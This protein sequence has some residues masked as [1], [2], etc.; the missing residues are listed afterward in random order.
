MMQLSQE[1][2]GMSP[3]LSRSKA[4]LVATIIAVG[5]LTFSTSPAAASNHVTSVTGPSSAT[6][7]DANNAITFTAEYDCAGLTRNAVTT[8]LA[9]PEL[10]K[11][12]RIVLTRTN[13]ASCNTY[14]GNPYGSAFIVESGTGDAILTLTAQYTAAIRDNGPN[15]LQLGPGHCDPGACSGKNLFGF[16]LFVIGSS[17][18]GGGFSGS[19]GGSGSTMPDPTVSSVA[20]AV[21]QSAA[22]GVEG[23]SNAVLIRRDAVVPVVSR[24]SSG[25][26]ARG[27]VV[28]EADG[29]RATV[30]SSS[31]ARAGSGVIVPPSGDLEVS[32][33]GGLAPGAVVEVWVNSTPRLVAAA[34]VP[35]TYEEGDSLD[36]TVP[37][38]AP[39]D[40]GEPVEDGAHTL[41]VRMYTDAGFEVLSTGITVG[42]V[43][44][45]RIPAGSGPVRLDGVLFALLG[46][47]GLVGLAVRRTVVSG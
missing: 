21:E 7:V 22:A 2:P 47:A 15:R 32:I 8:L 33:V 5:S 34:L 1:Q 4:A 41:Q 44:P 10:G 19:G 39:L 26:G 12:Y 11:W 38:G 43:V 45:T 9:E 30:A 27:G 46:A 6:G 31:G 40:G 36:F 18:R 17:A 3:R 29:L 35:D 23:T 16:E 37:L 14:T 24:V 13:L 25:V 42:G 20:V 28:L